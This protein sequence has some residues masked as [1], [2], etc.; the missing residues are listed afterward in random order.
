MKILAWNVQGAKKHQIREEIRFLHKAQQPDLIF[1][2]ET[3]ASE[4]TSKQ[5]LPRLGFEHYDFTLPVNHSGGIWVLWNNKN[6][7]AQVISKED[8]AI[9]MLVF[10]VLI[11]KFSIISGIYA[12]AQSGQKDAFWSYLQNLNRVI[13]TPW[14]LI[15]DFNEL[16]CP[17]DKHG[18]A[19]V[20]PSRLTRL[21]EFLNACQAISVPVLGRSFTWKKRVYN[22]LV[23]EKL[24]R[25]IGRQDWCCQYPESRVL[26]G[27]FT[28]SDHS[29]ILL[30]TQPDQIGMHKS[31]FR[32]QPH[33]SSYR[34]VRNIVNKAWTGRNSGTPMFQL[35][36]KL[37]HI[38]R[39]LKLWCRSK[40]A[41]FRKQI[42]KNTAQ[43]HFV[44]SQLIA[45]PNSL[46][47][48]AWYTRLLKQ[49]ER[50]LLF[51]KRFWGNFAR[52]KWLVDGDRN[53]RYF[54]SS[55]AARKRA[56]TII[57]LK[58]ATGV[59]VED[60]PSISQLIIRD[61]SRR[62]SSA[63][64]GHTV[65]HGTVAH[66]LVTPMEND[67]LIKPVTEAEIHSAVFQMDPHKAPGSDGFGPSFFQDHWEIVKDRLVPAIKDFF[68][69]GHLLKAVNHTLITLIPKIANPKLPGHYR[70]ISLCTTLYKIVAKILANRMRPI[71]QRIIHWS[72]SAFIPHRTIH[73]NIL[74]THEIM[75]KFK[76]FKGKKGYAALKLDMEK[77]YDRIEWDFLLTCLQQLGFHDKWIRWIKECI[78]T[79][80]YSVIINGEPTGFFKPTRGLRQG[81]PL[82]PYLF[83][84]CM[85]VLAIRLYEQSLTAKSGIGIKIAASAPRIPC[86]FFADDSLLFCK[87]TAQACR[88]LKRILDSF[89]EQ[90]GQLVNYHKSSIVFS[91]NTSNMDKQIVSGIFNIPQSAPI[92][93]Y[94]GC[95]IFQ[96]R[97]AP[98]LFQNLIAK[99]NAKLDSW[100]SKCFSKAGR[101][102]LIQSNLESLP[103]HV[104]QCYPLPTRITCQID[105][106]H[107]EFLWK[108]SNS[109]KGMPLVAWD[110]IC[111][112]KTL[113]GLGLRKSAAVNTACL[114]KLGWRFLTQPENPWV[115][116]MRA[117]YGSPEQFFE[118]RV[119]PTDSW[120]W[121][122]ILRI[123]SFI[124]Q[125]IRWTVG[126]GCSIKFWT[127]T[128]CGDDSL[129]S[130][131]GLDP[132]N[133]PNADLRVSDFI[134]PGKQWDISKL[135][136]YLPLNIIQSIL[137][138]PVPYTAVSD[139]FCWGFTGSG[140]F[141]TKS[142]TWKAHDNID[143]DHPIWPYKWIWK[144]DVMPKVRVFLWQLC[145]NA[146]PGRGILFHR[147]L[148][149]DPF[150]PGCPSEIEDLDH[151]FMHC[152]MAKA[153][154]DMAV[155]HQWLPNFPFAHL[156]SHI[157]DELHLLALR[158]Y[159]WLSRVA[160]LLWSI[161]KSR[162]AIIF[163]NEGSSAMGT[164]L[165][166]KRNWAE[167]KLRTTSLSG[168]FHTSS[169]SPRITHPQPVPQHHIGWKLP[170]GGFTKLNFDGTKSAAGTAAG[171]V[172]RN[173]K[174]GFIMA[175][176]RYLE[177][178]PI[179]VAEATALRDGIST[180]L[181][182]GHRRLEVEGDNLIVIQAVRK[183]I[184][185]PWQIAPIVEDIWNMIT[186]CDSIS[187][188]HIYREGNLAADWIA[189]YGCLIRSHSLYYCMSPPSRDFLFILSDDNLGRTLARRAT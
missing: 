64:G 142:A 31:L 11:Q 157:R 72:Q 173:W 74:I 46:R 119:K 62:L 32:Y 17:D 111:R 63:N 183:H 158:K 14:C 51:N 37:R 139:S 153:V 140:D 123:R 80:S 100:K 148:Q 48:N 188:T 94:L 52:K 45:D 34:E 54:H 159:P 3:M 13:D 168:D 178:A 180:A 28:Y 155:V 143:K 104:M 75:N 76:L 56:N 29:Y 82:S 164:L 185:P 125:G 160:L 117:K 36:S 154:W 57:R 40:F 145:H 84:I 101:V 1:V 126:N 91:K 181:R 97:P 50:L 187:F 133:I 53:S 92:G 19:P 182:E 156:G 68:N 172:L 93:K 176:T 61:L 77:A 88:T 186:S 163:K 15:G 130:K 175:G 131:L 60:P 151:I 136:N 179:L 149:I 38:K 98:D 55:A 44:E 112:P 134:T 105:R 114:A 170:Q 6:I 49:R 70:P 67:N 16:E 137:S 162:N 171:F 18:G 174:G 42:D 8:R 21:P 99:T 9:H 132:G 161:W 169:H 95:A 71:L 90:S 78:S 127:D 30:N 65:T 12:P 7:L 5:I 4:A 39:D 79:V 120:V 27:P 103:T 138:I 96:G 83:I 59:W 150:C 43:L 113:G 26:T 73:D 41:N 152:H 47:L 106:T 189:K 165:R 146:L 22:Q 121:K 118:L 116:Q 33:W 69:S 147:G 115:Q 167:W 81:D 141:T 128:W 2:I 124:K 25:A 110:K 58:D 86:L 144:L 23:Y 107:R 85:N 184:C 89:C 135:Q 109:N 24:D 20:S 122:S 129:V 35:T 10:D 177:D 108:T 87:A 102:V 166:A 66:P